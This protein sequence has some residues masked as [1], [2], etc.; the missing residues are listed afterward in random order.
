LWLKIIN[1]SISN[2]KSNIVTQDV[3]NYGGI[4][5][6]NVQRRLDLLYPGQYELDIKNLSSSFE[7]NL[8]LHLSELEMSSIVQD[9]PKEYASLQKVKARVV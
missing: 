2:S 1:F 9:Q 7:V 5:L 4:G 3:V 6:Q 8:R